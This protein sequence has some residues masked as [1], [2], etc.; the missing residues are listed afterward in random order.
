[1]ARLLYLDTETTGLNTSTDEIIE[2]ALVGV[3]EEQR[4]ER[5]F[6]FKPSVPISAGAYDTHGI[7]EEDLS[8]EPGFAEI[9]AKIAGA[10]AWSDALLGYNVGFDLAI[11][12]RQLTASG[13]PGQLE[14]KHVIDAYRLW[15]HVEP[16]KLEDAATRFI[17][18]EIEN[19]HSALADTIAV[20]QIFGQMLSEFGLSEKTM[21]E[22]ES[23]CFPDKDLWINGSQKFQWEDSVPVICFGKHKGMSLYVLATETSYL[24]WILSADFPDNEKAIASFVTSIAPQIDEATF[25]LRFADE[26]GSPDG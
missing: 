15:Q 18:A 26:F 21:A 25:L 13:H 12:D 6:R 24:E 14:G 3:D 17:G 4:F 10:I 19:A 16:R 5:E 23:L 1:M 20:E 22:L 11:L 8:N 9:A 2:L 7:G